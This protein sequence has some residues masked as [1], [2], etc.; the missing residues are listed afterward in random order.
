MVERLETR[1]WSH[2]ASLQRTVLQW[3]GV[4]GGREKKWE[5]GCSSEGLDVLSVSLHLSVNPCFYICS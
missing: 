5:E 4:G 2:P 1:A 3:M